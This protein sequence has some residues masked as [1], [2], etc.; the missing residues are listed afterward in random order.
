ME[1]VWSH[2]FKE[3]HC[4]PAERPLILAEPAYSISSQREKTVR[5][6]SLIWGCA[7]DEIL[8]VLTQSV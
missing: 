1:A 2:G 6:A 4:D 3:L 5:N 8:T 7:Q